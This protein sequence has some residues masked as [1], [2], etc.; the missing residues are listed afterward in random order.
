MAPTRRS[1]SSN[2]ENPDIA[3]IIAHQL[4][5][6]IPQ[7]VTQMTNNMN[8][9]NVNNGNGNNRNGGNGNGGNNGCSYK[10]FLTCNPRDYDGKGG[11]IA[12]TQWIE[13]MESVMD[14]SG[15]AD[16]QKVKYA[17]S[18]FI[19]K[20][21]TW[22]NTQVQERGHEAV[23]GMTWE[24][25]KALLVEEF[26][27]S[28]EMKKLE[29]E[30]W[31][32]T[33]VR[34]NHI[35]YTD[36]FHELAKLVPHLVTPELK[37]I[38]RCGTLSKGS[39][40]RKE[41]EE[42]SKQGDS[43]N[44]NKRVKVGKGYV[45]AAPPRNGPGHFAR[46]CRAPVNANTRNNGNQA[47]G[48]AFNVNAIGA[49][50][51][52][53]VVIG[54]FSLNDH[55]ATVRFDSGADISFISTKFVSLLNVK[56]SIMKP[57]YVI[58]VADSK[59][60]EV[61]RIIR[62]CKLELGNSLFTIDLIPLSYG[63]FDVILGMYWLSKHKT[64]IICHEKVVR[65]PLATGEMLQVQGECALK[66]S[67]S[68]KSTKLNEHTLEDIHVVQEFPEEDHEVYL[69]LVLE[70]LKNERLFS[71]FSKCEFWL[72]EVHF[73]GHVVNSNCIH[74]DPSKIEAVKN[75]KA[76]K[77]PS[78]IR[79]FMGLAEQEEAFQTLKDNLCNAPILLFL[80]G[81]KDFVVYYDASNQG[82]G[83]VLMKKG[84]VIAYASRQ[85]KIHEKNY[86][87]YDLELGA[88]VFALKIWRHYLYGTI[89]VIYTYHK[90][91]QHIFN[92]KELNMHQRR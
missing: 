35:T 9:N 58:E 4:Q 6:V 28:N 56:P 87:M 10:A 83:C 40:K 78:E 26:C 42:T 27:P 17:T 7:I 86:T 66:I 18:S 63:S 14:N 38:G 52:P 31:S 50:Q 77:T 46:D 69:R 60:V 85:L 20:A 79:S 30:S 2:G 36:Q 37:R 3:A 21:L 91:L 82:L 64:M 61:D 12:L 51:D 67:T 80:D 59:N 19:N 71:K 41:V 39:E 90:R 32:H 54:T 16:N 81:A 89:S 68:L 75:W 45:A 23:V 33:M 43:R 84:K 11:A 88:V 55:F 5:N 8:N 92:Q 65:I 13:K 1:N 29:N 44:D 34:A 22:W 62:G 15:C 57:G 53:K 74:V 72:Q 73:L 48:R 25:F 76:P 47:R 70:L 24:E 49:L